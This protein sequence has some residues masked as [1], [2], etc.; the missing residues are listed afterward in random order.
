MQYFLF[1]YFRTTNSLIRI[2]LSFSDSA[3]IRPSAAKKRLFICSNSLLSHF[4]FSLLSLFCIWRL[5]SVAELVHTC[6]IIPVTSIYTIWLIPWLNLFCLQCIQLMWHFL[7]RSG[8]Y[9]F[10]NM[11]NSVSLCTESETFLKSINGKYLL[12]LL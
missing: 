11:L 7:T 12:Y 10:F 8:F 1:V 2:A 3:K 6:F 9:V 4:S 5:N